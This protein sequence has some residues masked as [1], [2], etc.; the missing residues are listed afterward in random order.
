[1]EPAES[2]IASLKEGLFTTLDMS[3][4]HSRNPTA[5]KWKAPYR[6]LQLREVVYWRMVDLLEQ[7]IILHKHG[8]ALGARILTRSALETLAILI[9]LNQQMEKVL[10]DKLSFHAFSA[11]TE[12]LLLGSRDGSTSITAINIL[13]IFDGCDRQYTGIERVYDRLSESA[14]P[15]Y[16]GMS[17]GYTEIYHKADTVNFSNRWMTMYGTH[18][19]NE[20]ELCI[21]AFH[22]EYNTVWPILFERW[23]ETRDT[24]LEATKNSAPSASSTVQNPVTVR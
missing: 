13:T 21:D 17:A 4:L 9:Y 5:H 1:M 20:I 18:I 10:E 7:S 14:H 8:H 6:S 16:E 19:F 2:L 22:H 23:I 24:E 15:N 3:S 12:V 11:K